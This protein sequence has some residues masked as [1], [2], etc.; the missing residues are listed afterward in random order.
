MR[1][2]EKNSMKRKTKRM[3][4]IISKRKKIKTKEKK[5]EGKLNKKHT[6]KSEVK[7]LK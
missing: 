5:K 1:R 6:R 4:L 3:S 2:E 7:E